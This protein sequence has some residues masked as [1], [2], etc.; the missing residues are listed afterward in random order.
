MRI[1]RG[2]LADKALHREGGNST[3]WEQAV[4]NLPI[5]SGYSLVTGTGRAEI[6]F[7]DAS[8]VYLSDNSVLTFNSLSTTDGV[9]FTEIALL[10]GT[11]SLNVQ[12]MVAHEFFN[13]GTPT[14]H[15]TIT[16]PQ[17]AYARIDSYMDA[18]SITP[19]QDLTFR[20]PS[21]AATR[22]Q[23]AGETMSFRHG[24]RILTPVPADAAILPAWDKWVAQRVAARNSAMSATMKDAAS[25][26]PFPD[27]MP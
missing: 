21:L 13:L 26:H 12:P 6:E 17:K 23:Y 22:T 20:M 10:S 5:E 1:S 7:E 18:V 11:A 24:V 14:D 8:T 25:P 3:G 4:T 15:I 19:Q 2:K 9:P 16:Y 27:W